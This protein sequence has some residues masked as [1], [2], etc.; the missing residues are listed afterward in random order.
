MNA[1]I[2]D[3]RCTLAGSDPT[4]A[5]APGY[6]D[7]RG[8]LHEASLFYQDS[9]FDP[10]EPQTWPMEWPS[11]PDGI[12]KRRFYSS[13]DKRRDDSTYSVPRNLDI[14]N[15][16]GGPHWWGE[17]PIARSINMRTQRVLLNIANK[18]FIDPSSPAYLR[19]SEPVF[20]LLIGQ[21][22]A[23]RWQESMFH[24]GCDIMD[25]EEYLRVLVLKKSDKVEGAFKRI[26]IMNDSTLLRR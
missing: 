3:A 7:I 19:P 14:S 9:D 12:Y 2:L 11:H 15:Y 1:Q 26:R 24:K 5:I 25:N 23:V 22:K 21:T 16:T 4:G 17:P 6:V 18:D 20:I 13:L 10:H 8:P